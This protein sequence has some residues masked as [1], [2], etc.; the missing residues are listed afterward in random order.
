MAAARLQRHVNRGRAP[1]VALQ[2]RR[3]CMWSRR[4]RPAFCAS[5][6]PQMWALAQANGTS[7]RTWM[8]CTLCGRLK[9]HSGGSADVAAV[10][11]SRCSSMTMCGTPAST[12]ACR[13]VTLVTR[14][15]PRTFAAAAA[16]RASLGSVWL[17]SARAPAVGAACCA[18][19]LGSPCARASPHIAATRAASTSVTAISGGPVLE[20]AAEARS[21]LWGAW[22]LRR[23]VRATQGAGGSPPVPASPV[24]R[25]GWPEQPQGPARCRFRQLC[26]SAATSRTRSCAPA[27]G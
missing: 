24:S 20:A 26:F 3:G 18:G 2:V 5:A 1:A 12:A 8:D 27:Y 9:S 6:Q 13:P 21:G 15:M 23:C 7:G 22:H 17:R 19:L 25:G 11:R 4:V 16:S 10:R 14:M